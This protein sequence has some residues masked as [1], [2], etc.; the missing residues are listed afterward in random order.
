ML[1]CVACLITWSGRL[2][3]GLLSVRLRDWGSLVVA[4]ALGPAFLLVGYEAGLVF[5][6]AASTVV[7]VWVVMVAALTIAACRFKF[8]VWQA[9]VLSIT[10]AVLADNLRL[11]AIHRNEIPSVA[12]VFWAGGTLLS[13]PFPI[14]FLLR[15]L[16][17]RQRY[18]AAV[19]IGAVAFLLWLGIRKITG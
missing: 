13:A 4:T 15:P 1:S 10:I 3:S 12:Y 6:S 8:L 14:Y 2:V 19:A 17:A 5:R 7:F 11:H 18:I 16:K 9:A